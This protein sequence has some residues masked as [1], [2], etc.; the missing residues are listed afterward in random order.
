MVDPVG[1][2]LRRQRYS[3]QTEVTCR[4]GILRIDRD[5]Y[6]QQIQSALIMLRSA[7]A[8]FEKGGYEVQTIRIT[9]QPFPQYTGG[10]SRAEAVEFFK[11]LDDFRKRV[12]T[13]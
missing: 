7:K 5:H 4:N 2:V 9:T 8:S 13:Y 6:A 3:A 1:F 11:R 12:L 10:L